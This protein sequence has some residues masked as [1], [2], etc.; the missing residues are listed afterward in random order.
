M[1]A[2]TLRAM[3]RPEKSSAGAVEEEFRPLPSH[4]RRC[5]GCG[6]EHP[7]GLHMQ[8]VGSGQVVR[9]SFL[10]T[11]HHQGAPGLAH[12]GVIAAALD[13]AMGFLIYLAERPAVTAHLEVDYRK[14]VPIGS[15]LE[16]EARLDR[17]EGR[18]LFA[19]VIGRV[20]GEVHV[21]GHSLFL[22]VG[23]EHFAPHIALA[24]E[25]WEHPYNP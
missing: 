18:K 10:V 7:T 8:V 6:E 16:L 11:E 20:D 22:Q 5:F 3:L 25:T 19:S 21:E 23:V 2:G 24:G 4:Y 1:A 13:E 15:R 9:G 17:V 14:P 12:G